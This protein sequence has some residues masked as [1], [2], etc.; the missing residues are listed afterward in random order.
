MFGFV[1][2]AGVVVFSRGDELW[3]YTQKNAI[4]LAI[5]DGKE[6]LVTQIMMDFMHPA[7][8]ILKLDGVGNTTVRYVM[9]GLGYALPLD[10]INVDGVNEILAVKIVDVV[11][12][13]HTSGVFLVDG[14]TGFSISEFL[15]T[16]EDEV[17]TT[18]GQVVED[19]DGDGVRDIAVEVIKQNESGSDVLLKVVSSKK[20]VKL[21]GFDDAVL[22][23]KCYKN[24]VSAMVVDDVDKDGLPDLGVITYKIISPSPNIVYPTQAMQGFD[25]EFDIY[26]GYDGKLLFHF[27]FGGK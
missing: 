12:G 8:Y 4:L 5:P 24:F 23:E 9:S 19:L 16:S 26:R 3:N 6:I 7:T 27:E 14:K 15:E 10:D 2:P 11:D 18:I 22:W 25:Y 13:Y 21:Q 17:A 1:E 20:A